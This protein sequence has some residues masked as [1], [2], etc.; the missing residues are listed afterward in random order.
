VAQKQSV[1]LRQDPSIGWGL[2]LPDNESVSA[3]DKALGKDAKEPFQRLLAARSGSPRAALQAGR[4][5]GL[6]ATILCRRLGS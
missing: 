1:D 4:A 6:I 2:V 3:A 5:R